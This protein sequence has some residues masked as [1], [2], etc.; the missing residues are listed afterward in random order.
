MLAQNG[1]YDWGFTV[2]SFT[3]ENNLF[4]DVQLTKDGIGKVEFD[5]MGDLNIV[6]I[7]VLS[8]GPQ[9]ASKKELNRPKRPNSCT[10]DKTA[11][12][13]EDVSGKLWLAGPVQKIK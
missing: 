6:S 1:Q 11:L 12:Y 4:V 5:H 2:K 3:S 7:K 13:Q 8:K 10:F 9:K